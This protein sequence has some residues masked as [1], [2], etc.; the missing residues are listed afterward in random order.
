MSTGWKIFIVAVIV[1]GIGAAAFFYNRSKKNITFDF[2][3]GGNVSDIL[4]LLQGSR[5]NEKA[6]IY[7]DIPVST[8]VKNNGNAKVLMQNIA[9]SVSYG[10]QQILQTKPNSAALASVDVP[11]KSQQ[12]V[13]DNVQLLINESTIKFF[14]ELFKGNK[15]KVNYNFSSIIGGKQRTFS[16]STTVN[17]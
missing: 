14:T 2:N 9:G 15:P 1:I 10:G 11:K 4:S 13:S 7:F 6:G 12:T 8:I 5:M 3:M 17:K 16:N